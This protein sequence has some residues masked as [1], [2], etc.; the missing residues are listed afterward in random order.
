LGFDGPFAARFAGPFAVGGAGGAAVIDEMRSVRTPDS[1]L[2]RI[3]F[4]L[5]SIG[6]AAFPGI[7]VYLIL[8]LLMPNEAD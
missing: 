1:T 7:L 5:V 3:V 8:W 4:V 2:V 6:S